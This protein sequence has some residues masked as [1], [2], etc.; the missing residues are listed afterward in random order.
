MHT[1][2]EPRLQSI[3]TSRPKSS[4]SVDAPAASAEPVSEG[5]STPA[6]PAFEGTS[7]PA[8]VPNT[9][10]KA[11]GGTDVYMSMHS[12]LDGHVDDAELGGY[13]SMLRHHVPSPLALY[14]PLLASG[15]RLNTHFR[16]TCD[17]TFNDLST[18]RPYLSPVACA[19]VDL[20][21]R[22]SSQGSDGEEVSPNTDVDT[23]N[24]LG[25]S[26]V[27][28]QLDDE[29]SFLSSQYLTFD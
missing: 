27:V 25:L 12:P 22:A 24:L 17:A 1:Y 3:F 8:L 18:G 9:P 13:Y 4:P 16:Y 7:T 19:P 20:T 15:P 21:E 26:G 23:F 29:L 5:A 11:E 6:E 28:G 2:A 10:I 14:S